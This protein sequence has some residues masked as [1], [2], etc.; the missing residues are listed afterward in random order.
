MPRLLAR[1]LLQPGEAV[2]GQPAV[3]D[4]RRRR[5][6]PARR[7]ACSRVKRH[8][9]ASASTSANTLRRPAACSHTRGSRSPGVSITSAPLASGTSSRCVVAWRP[10]SS[11]A[12][13]GER[14]PLLAGQVVE[15]R[16]L[17]DARRAEQD[18]GAAR[19]QPGA[20]R[21]EP[22]P[23]DDADRRAPARCRR[24][25]RARRA[26]RPPGP[27]HRSALDSTTT[28]LGLRVGGERE[29][30]LEPSQ[31][32]VEVE[33]ADDE[34]DV[35]VRGEHLRL[36]APVAGRAG[37]PAAG[38]AAAR[39][40]C[41]WPGRPRPSRRRRAGRPRSARRGS[42]ARTARRRAARRRSAR[43]SRPRC[44]AATRAGIEVR[45]RQRRERGVEARGPAE[46]GE[47]ARKGRG[48]RRSPCERRVRDARAGRARGTGSGGR[49]RLAAGRASRRL[50]GDVETCGAEAFADQGSGRARA[51]VQRG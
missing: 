39:G 34:R 13:H 6:S 16:G 45:A 9:A 11:P 35:D 4:R 38:A 30:P 33:R 14:R 26:P 8:C 41:R 49:R 47:A 5:R 37:D 7:G 32:E 29:E 51:R 3:G 24:A 23:V 18:G 31:V 36:G 27:R 17:A 46:G 28:A 20:E 43:S 2:G 48:Q 12:P 42:A 15:Q 22:G 10:R 50:G 25:R 1:E 21:V 19:L 40:R 44:T